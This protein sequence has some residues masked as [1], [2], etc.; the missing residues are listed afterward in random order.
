MLFL[1]P[2]QQCQSTEGN[3]QKHIHTTK[4]SGQRSSTSKVLVMTHTHIEPIDCSVWT[5][6]MVSKYFLKFCSSK[7][8]MAA[9]IST[10]VTLRSTDCGLVRCMVCLS[11]PPAFTSTHCTDPRRMARLSSPVTTENILLFQFIRC[12]LVYS[13]TCTTL[14]HHDAATL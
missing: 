10:P 1:T 7:T 14:L 11:T 13:V 9:L 4:Y 5:T 8:H 6:K 12:L 3:N 2:N